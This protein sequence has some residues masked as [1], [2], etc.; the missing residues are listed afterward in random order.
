MRARVGRPPRTDPANAVVCR[1]LGT[2]AQSTVFDW[3]KYF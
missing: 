3:L 1:T 2:P